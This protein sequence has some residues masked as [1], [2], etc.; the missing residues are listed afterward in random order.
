MLV[1]CVKWNREFNINDIIN[2]SS[3][4]RNNTSC[5]DRDMSLR[6]R[7]SVLLEHYLDRMSHGF[8]VEKRF[9][10][11]HEYHIG[12]STELRQASELVEYLI[13]GKIS[14]EALFSSHTEY[15]AHFASGLWWNTYGCTFGF[16]D[17]CC[18][19]IFAIQN[20]IKIFLRSVD[21]FRRAFRG[22]ETYLIIVGYSFPHFFWEICHL[23]DGIN[24]LFI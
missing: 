19:D 18:F 22:I 3:N 24:L 13:W 4:P 9:T 16:G 10:H 15:T 5:W 7:K 20:F 1:R 6:Q 12:K 2:H 23:P 21:T 17:I 14:L 11:S 8:I